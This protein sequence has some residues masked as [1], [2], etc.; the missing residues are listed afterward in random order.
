MENEEIGSSTKTI[1]IMRKSSNPT[2]NLDEKIQRGG[3]PYGDTLKYVKKIVEFALQQENIN[4]QQ[5]E[6]SVL[7]CIGVEN[8]GKEGEVKYGS[9]IGKSIGA[10]YYLG[11]LSSIHQKPINQ[12]VAAT[13]FI[14][15]KER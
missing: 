6:I 3:G 5:Y 11:L 7:N 1:F 10:A 4:P 13:G 15:L 8:F 14:N 9:V 2:I 12:V